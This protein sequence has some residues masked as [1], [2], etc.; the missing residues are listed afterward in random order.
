MIKKLLLSVIA[1]AFANSLM[2]QELSPVEKGQWVNLNKVKIEKPVRTTTPLTR[3]A[4]SYFWWGYPDGGGY[5]NLLVFDML[6]EMLN[7]GE[8]LKGQ[9][10]YNLAMEVPASFGGTLVDSVSIGFWDVSKITNLKVWFAE[11]KT[12]ATG[13]IALPASAD[14]A[15]YSFSVSTASFK[16]KSFNDIKLPEPYTIPASGCIVGYSFTDAV[17]TTPI[18]LHATAGT[19]GGFYLQYSKGILTREW[20]D[21]SGWGQGDLTINLHMDATNLTKNQ[22]SIAGIYGDYVTK[23]GGQGSIEVEVKNEAAV[24]VNEVGYVLYVKGVA[25]PEKTAQLPSPVMN[26]AYG[27]FSINN[28]PAEKEGLNSFDIEITKVNGEPNNTTGVRRGTGNIIALNSFAE[29]TS[30]IEEFTGSWCGYCPRGTVGLSKLKAKY[31]DKI[32][33]LAGHYGDPMECTPYYSFLAQNA[34]GFPDAIYDRAYHADP[35]IGDNSSYSFGADAVVDMLKKVYP[36]EASLTIEA[37]WTDATKTAIDAKAYA[38]FLYS[39]SDENPYAVVFILTEDGMTGTGSDWYQTNYYNDPSFA[40][41]FSDP[42]MDKYTKGSSAVKET[43]NHVIVEAW[44]SIAGFQNNETTIVNG[45]TQAYKKVLDI[46]ANKLIQNKSNLSLAALLINRNHGRIVNAAQ[47]KLSNETGINGVNTENVVETANYN[48]GGVRT[49]G[50]AKGLN[51]VRMSN[52][53]VVKVIR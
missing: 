52:G 41:A 22:V 7:G 37:H 51:I 49:S 14:K 30:V 15:D 5:V 25:Q 23:V 43:Y 4:S 19:K 13:K 20:I 24:P 50:K 40:A 3:A 33:T 44:N 26:N 35:Y 31:G 42:D 32:I 48:I 10:N 21:G 1:I 16:N 36:S 12:D 38:T 11:F 2:A 34:S 39:R 45:Q 28:I 17:G 29:R 18:L 6:S 8:I 9:K 53:K 27:Y 46:S 47:V